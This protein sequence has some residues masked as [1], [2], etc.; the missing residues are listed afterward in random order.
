MPI[1]GGVVDLAESE[2]VD[3][4]RLAQ[5]IGIGHYMCRIEQ[6]SMAEPAERPLFAVRPQYPLAKGALVEP[7][8]DERGHVPPASFICWIGNTHKLGSVINR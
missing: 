8:P 4:E 2:T 1:E 5:F 3:D 6:L 7:T